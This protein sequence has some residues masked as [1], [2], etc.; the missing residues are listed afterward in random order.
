MDLASVFYGSR[1]VGNLLNEKLSP[2]LSYKILKIAEDMNKDLVKIQ[3]IRDEIYSS[4][5]SQ[6]EKESEFL[7]FLYTEKTLNVYNKIPLN[8]LEKEEIKITPNL[9]KMLLPFLEE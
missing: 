8:L 9:M 6:E 3:S 2:S 1:I 5:K 4:E 7:N